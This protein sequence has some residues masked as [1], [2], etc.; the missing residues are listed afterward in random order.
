MSKFGILISVFKN[1]TSI[2]CFLFEQFWMDFSVLTKS[3]NA[4]D[5][6]A[7]GRD[8]LDLGQVEEVAG[9]EYDDGWKVFR[10][11]C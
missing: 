5:D 9:L 7:G 10:E 4:E 11:L 2:N 1:S 3:E 8:P 6:D